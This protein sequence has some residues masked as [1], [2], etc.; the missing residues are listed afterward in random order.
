M[1]HKIPCVALSVVPDVTLYHVGPALD[2]GPL[3]AL[4]YF[5][6]SGPDS[7]TLD[8][9]NQPIQFLHGEQIRSFSMD[10]P[11]HENNLPATEALKTW[12]EDYG[13]GFN[14]L[15][16]FF[17]KF[18]LAI[19]FAIRQKLTLPE[20]ICVAGLSRGGFIAAHIAA[21]DERIR[22]ILAFAPITKLRNA[23]E[24]ASLREHPTLRALD[25]TEL[26]DQLSKR[27]VRLYIG[28]R[29]TR[30]DTRSCFEFAMTLVEKAHEKRVRSPQVEFLMTPSIG[31]HGHG[32]SPETFRAGATWIKQCL[33]I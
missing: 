19:E 21:R 31:Q 22:S 8:P 2:H 16:D 20:K 17:E 3:P 12:A 30:V 7:L 10:L 32:T 9:Y 5:A 4:F 28:N 25:L 6:L 23:K 1:V 24:F 33:G 14:C 29:D 15:E 26:S 13:R 27:H 18:S 11:A